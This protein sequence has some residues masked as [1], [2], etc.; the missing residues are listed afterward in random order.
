M[1]VSATSPSWGT[2]EYKMKVVMS[3]KCRYNPKDG[4]A[5]DWHK[6]YKQL[7]RMQNNGKNGNDYISDIVTT[8]RDNS[9]TILK[10]TYTPLLNYGVQALG[11]S[12]SASASRSQMTGG[13]PAASGKPAG[14]SPQTG[15]KP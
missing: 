11:L 12:G 7:V 6:D 1:P 3:Q 13:A 2:G 5:S 15:Q 14:G 4:R 9:F 8:F 10:A